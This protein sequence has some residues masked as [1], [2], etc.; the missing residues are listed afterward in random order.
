MSLKLPKNKYIVATIKKWHFDSFYKRYGGGDGEWLLISNP[1]D[2]NFEFVKENNPRYM[3]FPHWSWIVPNEIIHN[4]ECV[5]FHSSDVPYGR[6]GSPIQNLIIRG[7]TE[8]KISALKMVEELD[9][10][11]VYMKRSLSLKGRAQDIFENSAEII[12]EMMQ[13]IVKNEPTPQPQIGESIV[14]KRRQ[15]SENLLPMDSD[16]NHLYNHIR[17][18]DA[19]TYPTSH[20]VHG[21]YKIEFSHAKFDNNELTAQSKITM[22]T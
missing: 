21:K 4:Y 18:L 6:G 20:I 2:L 11:P 19:E 17:M 3:F 1:K 9:A 16:L 10:G 15:E 12:A 8:T 7:V 22:I 13:E 14:F 5:C